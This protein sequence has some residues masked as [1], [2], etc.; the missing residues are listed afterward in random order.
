MDREVSS[1]VL[2]G[3]GACSCVGVQ[4]LTPT[5]SKEKSD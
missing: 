1:T 3:Q 4:N 5:Q 2:Q